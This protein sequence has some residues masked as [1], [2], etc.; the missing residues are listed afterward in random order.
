MCG[1]TAAYDRKFSAEGF[2]DG[3][4]ALEIREVFANHNA[5]QHHM[6]NYQKC[7]MHLMTAPIDELLSVQKANQIKVKTKGGEKTDSVL[8]RIVR[9]SLN[10]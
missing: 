8:F 9:I 1:C 4:S 6:D 2:G 3:K 5:S 7:K 10:T